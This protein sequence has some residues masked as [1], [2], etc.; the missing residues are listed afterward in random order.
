MA[1]SVKLTDLCSYFGASSCL[2]VNVVTVYSGRGDDALTGKVVSYGSPACITNASTYGHAI[3]LGGGCETTHFVQT[4]APSLYVNVALT[5]YTS[6]TGYYPMGGNT[7][8]VDNS[9][10]S[11]FTEE[12]IAYYFAYPFAVVFF[13]FM[14]GHVIGI[15]KNVIRKI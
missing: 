9:A 4:V 8:F 6:K 14:L 10:P 7:M 12:Q 5:D 1:Y 15:I 13:F 11:S 3:I 2:N